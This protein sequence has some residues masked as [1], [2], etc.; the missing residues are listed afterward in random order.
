MT[1]MEPSRTKFFITRLP[2]ESASRLLYGIARGK[3]VAR[4]GLAIRIEFVAPSPERDVQE[5]VLVGEDATGPERSACEIGRSPLRLKGERVD[6]LDPRRRVRGWR[7]VA[8]DVDFARFAK[9]DHVR[10]LQ[11]A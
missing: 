11:W 10:H 3:L 6:A 1:S 7:R 8:L 4:D 5:S 9:D 2:S